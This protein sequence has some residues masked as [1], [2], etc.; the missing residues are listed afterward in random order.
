MSSC[1]HPQA[2]D[3]EGCFGACDKGPWSQNLWL[4][5]GWQGF[6][7]DK[8]AVLR[9]PVEGH[10]EARESGLLHSSADRQTG[11]LEARRAKTGF[12]Q[13]LAEISQDLTLTFP[14]L[15]GK[16]VDFDE[17]AFSSSF[18]REFPMTF[19]FQ[20]LE[21]VQMLLVLDQLLKYSSKQQ[22]LRNYGEKLSVEAWVT[23]RKLVPK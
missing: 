13:I 1:G 10:R 12:H 7:T 21:M 22:L 6:Q 16:Y 19:S 14:W 8:N 4:D 23:N 9:S 17:P 20:W 18:N 2:A 15:W 5:W 3:P 11:W